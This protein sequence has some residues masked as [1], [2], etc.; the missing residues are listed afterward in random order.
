MKFVTCQ[1]SVLKLRMHQVIYKFFVHRHKVLGHRESS[2]MGLAIPLY[3]RQYHYVIS[4]I[5]NF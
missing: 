2:A 4:N 1:V 3:S 5:L